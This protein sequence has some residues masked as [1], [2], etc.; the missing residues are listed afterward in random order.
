M[1][2]YGRPAQ[3]VAPVVAVL[4]ACAPLVE[5]PAPSANGPRISRLEFDPI[6][7]VAGCTV[8]MRFRVEASDAEVKRGIVRWSVALGRTRIIEGTELN[9]Q[10][11]ASKESG[12]VTASL[13]LETSGHYRYRVQVEDERGRRSNVLEQDIRVEVPWVWWVTPCPSTERHRGLSIRVV[14]QGGTGGSTASEG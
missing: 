2:R 6:K 14:R 3:F 5:M 4:A 7:H 8:T 10:T 9:E 11:F 13:R 12:E 1:T